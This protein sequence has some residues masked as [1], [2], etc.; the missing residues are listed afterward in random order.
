MK[1]SSIGIQNYQ[2]VNRQENSRP[3]TAERRSGTQNSDPVLIQPQSTQPSS[4][5]AVKAPTGT[6][7]DALSPQERQA[8]ELLFARFK[9]GGRFNAAIRAEVESSGE[10]GVG[11]IID[12]KV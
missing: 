6:Y 12:V 1:I 2:Q 9:E 3:E 4:I 5:L 11:N 7:A 8:L 10:S